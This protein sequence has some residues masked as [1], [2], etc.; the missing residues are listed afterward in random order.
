MPAGLLDLLGDEVEPEIVGRR[1][2]DRLVF[3]GADAFEPG[4]LQ[5]VEQELEVFFRLAAESGNHVSRQ[6]NTRYH[7]SDVADELQVCL[8]GVVM[9][10]IPIIYTSVI[11]TNQIGL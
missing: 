2:L 5:P 6:E 10:C 3:E 4:L 8:P 1:A 7:F 9:P 11:H